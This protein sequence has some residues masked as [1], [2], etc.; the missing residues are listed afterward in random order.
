MVAKPE[1]ASLIDRDRASCLHPWAP[2][3]DTGPRFVVTRAERCTIQTA[4]GARYLDMVGAL[5]CVNVGY[6]RKEI[7]EA[8]VRQMNELPFYST[9]G[10]ATHPPAIE[11]AA[12]LSGYLPEGVNRVGFTTGGSTANDTALRFVQFY[13]NRLGQPE[14]KTVISRVNSYHGSSYLS[15]G[16]SYRGSDRNYLDQFENVRFLSS[17]NP[18]E[19]EPGQS[20]TSFCDARVAEFERAVSDIGAEHIACFIAEPVQ[21]SGGMIVPPIGYLSR[22]A[23]VCR[24]NDILTIADE[25]VTGFGR[26]GHMFSAEPEFDFRPDIVTCAKGITSGYLP[27]GG[28]AIAERLCEAAD[29]GDGTPY[30]NGYTYAGHPVVAAAALANLDI[31]EREALCARTAKLSPQ[32]LNALHELE[33]LP[34]VGSVRGLGLLAGVEFRTGKDRRLPFASSLGVAARVAAACQKRGVIVR[35]IGS[36]VGLSPPL[37]IEPG[38]IEEAVAALGGAIVEVTDQLRA[39]GAP[40]L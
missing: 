21:A 26:L 15:A 4:D 3:I 12:R 13:W 28:V 19:R 18:L 31:L 25:V 6:G 17:L 8:V 37:V 2:L 14:R 22:V 29:A 40:V 36:V 27:L 16:V 38:Q 30:S 23:E 34:I 5:W 20:E 39:E 1:I 10:R 24:R 9:F 7:G 35:P 32:F 33:D 11:L